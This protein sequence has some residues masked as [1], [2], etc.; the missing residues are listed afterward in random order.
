MMSSK[1]RM[2]KEGFPV[3]TKTDFLAGAKLEA[4]CYVSQA[5]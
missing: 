1:S 2:T 4:V 3:A 5:R